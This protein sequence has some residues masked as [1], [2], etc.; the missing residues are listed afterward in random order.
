MAGGKRGFSK[1]Q[2]PGVQGKNIKGDYNEIGKHKP[3]K[4]RVK[5]PVE[6]G[7]RKRER[8]S[9]CEESNMSPG[10][11]KAR[12][13]PSANR[14]PTSVVEWKSRQSKSG[15]PIITH[16]S[17][18]ETKQVATNSDAR[19]SLVQSPGG[20]QHPTSPPA[21]K[22]NVE[23]STNSKGGTI[24][25]DDTFLPDVAH[26]STPST[27][28]SHTSSLTQD[29]DSPHPDLWI[30]F[31]RL[32]DLKEPRAYFPLKMRNDGSESRSMLMGCDPDECNI[33]VSGLGVGPYHCLLKLE[34]GIWRDGPLRRRVVVQKIRTV[35]SPP[36]LITTI[37]VG[38]E[39]F[40][41]EDKLVLP[42][43]GILQLGDGDHYV[44]EAPEFASLYSLRSQIYGG[45]N[46]N[47]NVIQVQRSSDRGLFVVK[48]IPESHIRM[49]KMEIQIYKDLGHHPRVVQFIE[50]FYDFESKTHRL[51]L[52]A[53][54]MDLYHYILLMRPHA[55]D[56]LQENGPRWIKEITSGIKYIHDHE[57]THRDIK[58]Q[59]ILAFV[60]L[61]RV[62]MKITDMGLAR[63]NTQPWF[64]G[65]EHW[66]APGSFMAPDKNVKLVDCYGVGRVLFFLL[67]TYPW[68]R[69]SREPQGTCGCS[70]A[71]QDPCAKRQTAFQVIEDT[72]AG[73][74][75]LDFLKN[76]LVERPE[77]CNNASQ[78][79]NHLYITDS[80]AKQE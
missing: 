64:A 57:I 30:P 33:I 77:E 78:M 75:C 42:P 69:E 54:W 49:A 71:C 66:A 16:D 31:G 61:G 6:R 40:E 5:G 76:L 10:K 41:V 45:Q 36:S 12:A 39:A 44:Y 28:H 43:G 65:T 60:K 22:Y 58:P 25:Q 13:S 38:D 23:G 48:I 15:E 8:E 53:G 32:R 72:G 46:L 18:K 11:K 4:S 62:E 9:S 26:S 3:G 63:R 34:L 7:D 47:S 14:Q 24:S 1:K 67:T 73:D 27:S 79:L 51:V 50:A 52:E 2:Q 70:K 37:W 17:V 80:I 35:I 59:N 19:D 20:Q 29:I 55:Q 21:A 74:Q 56:V 68:P